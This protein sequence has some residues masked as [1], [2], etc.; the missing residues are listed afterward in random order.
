M[1][2]ITHVVA[3]CMTGS[4][5]FRTVIFIIKSLNRSWVYVI[6]AIISFFFSTWDKVAV[7]IV[8]IG[9]TSYQCK[10][11]L[12]SRGWCNHVARDH[13][14]YSDSQ[15]LSDFHFV[16]F[17]KNK[18]L[19]H[20]NSPFRT[21]YG[22]VVMGNSKQTSLCFFFLFISNSSPWKCTNRDSQRTVPRGMR[23]SYVVAL[24]MWRSKRK[25]LSISDGA[26]PQKPPLVLASSASFW[27]AKVSEEGCDAPPLPPSLYEYTEF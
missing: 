27:A 4:K 5:F 8:I 25:F 17:L 20:M 18:L 10:S 7:F 13:L 21:T 9:F 6:V 26:V 23:G 16:K 3:N 24:V 1:C 11:I 22:Y 15:T 12:I 19:W 14:Q 2:G